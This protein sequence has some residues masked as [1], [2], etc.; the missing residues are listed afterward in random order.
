MS[1]ELALW[2]GIALLAALFVTVGTFMVKALG[3]KGA[4]AVWAITAAGLA[5]IAASSF[6]LAWGTTP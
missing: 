3:W 6:L 5:V 1:K 2:L 4:L